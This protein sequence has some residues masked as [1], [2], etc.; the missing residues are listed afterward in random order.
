MLF[1]LWLFF[2]GGAASLSDSFGVLTSYYCNLFS[3]CS[4]ARATQAFAWLSWITLTALLAVVL[5]GAIQ[6]HRQAG[7]A[8][9]RQPYGQADEGEVVPQPAPGQAQ[10]NA[11][12]MTQATHNV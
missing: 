10:G 11:V 2:L 9:W 8:A 4:L 3:Y 1:V 12:P 6:G 7:K 5:F